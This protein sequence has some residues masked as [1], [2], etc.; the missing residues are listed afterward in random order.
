MA[1]LTSQT[2]NFVD[3]NGWPTKSEWYLE[4]LYAEGKERLKDRD[5][6]GSIMSKMIQ[7]RWS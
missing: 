2:L 1:I 6:D 4:H 5:Y 3:Q 7:E